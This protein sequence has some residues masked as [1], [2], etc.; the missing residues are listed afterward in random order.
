MHM[1]ASSYAIELIMH[2]AVYVILSIP[3]HLKGPSPA[4]KISIPSTNQ[5]EGFICPLQIFDCGRCWFTLVHL[6]TF[7]YLLNRRYTCCDWLDRPDGRTIGKISATAV[8]EFKQLIARST[9]L[10]SIEGYPH[11]FYC[12]LPQNKFVMHFV[13]RNREQYRA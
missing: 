3:Q 11:F 9:L 8:C 12:V 2:K 4:V 1:E 13:I 7:L 5:S 10:N 6:D